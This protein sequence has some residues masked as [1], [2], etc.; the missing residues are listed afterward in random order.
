MSTPQRITTEELAEE[1]N[2]YGINCEPHHSFNYVDDTF[3]AVHETVNRILHEKMSMIE[4]L[5]GR[6]N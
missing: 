1:F 3:T 4:F 2:K 5:M 6:M